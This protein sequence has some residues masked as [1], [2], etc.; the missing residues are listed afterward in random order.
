[1]DWHQSHDVIVVGAG[2]AGIEAALAA[3]RIGART[4]LLTLNLDTVGKMSCNPAIGGLAKGHLVRE[5]D[6]LGG[7]M[8]RAI[9]A[10]GIQFR[11]LNTRKGPAVWA[12]RAQADRAA[13]GAHMKRV[14]EQ[15]PGL[16]VLQAEVVGLWVQ[17]RELQG[18][19]SREG[20]RYPGR[21]V[22]LCPGTFLNGLAHVG[23][24]RFP[25][26]RA[27][28]PPSRE[29]AESLRDLGFPMG[30]LKTGTPPRLN[31][32]TIRWEDLE[33]QHGDPDPFP[34]SVD[35]PA[36]ERPQATCHITY[37]TARTHEIIRASLD[38]SPLYT[39][40]IEGVGPRYCPSI[41]D[42]VVRFADRDRHQVF[43]EPEGLDTSEV[44]PNGVS[45]S[46]PLDVQVAI[47]RSIPGLEEAEIL[48]PGYAIEY[49]FVDPRDLFPTLESKRLPGLFLAGQIN[50]TSGYE[51]AAAQGILAGINA[52]L[53]AGGSDPVTV[54]RH[55][56]YLGVLVD[57]LV[58][59]GIKEPYRMFTSRAEFRLLLRED[60][61][62][63][64]LTPLGLRVGSV[65]PERA[66]RFR[67]RT[68]RLAELRS[69]LK[70]TRVQPGPAVDR[71]LT[72]AGSSP[73]REPAALEDLLRRPGVSLEALQ[74]LA[75]GWPPFDRRDAVTAEVEVKYEGYVRRD[76]E[77]IEQVRRLEATPLPPDLDYTRIEGLAAEV[78]QILQEAR[79]LT[80]AQALR[81]PG[82]RPSAG[83]VLLVHLKRIGA[84]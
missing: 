30:R 47:V 74:P 65:L 28:E 63:L 33:V 2:H 23:L 58:T 4:L 37:T 20:V 83:P 13:Y 9:D 66:A 32:R 75:D 81:I 69:F 18:V 42:K 61:A 50:G 5:V 31:G 16:T 59:K 80:L 57:D 55:E 54:A 1:M 77:G 14:V 82:V 52:A 6:A 64:R 70:H 24:N 11:R 19:V 3:A 26:G 49:D 41:E 43:L 62:D 56:G 38:R 8:G 48:R 39:G 40:V 73:L 21:T 36:I 27:G 25:A 72:A 51:E 76:L 17:G 84:L 68:D 79:P 10:T 67:R 53:R 78:R 15:Q 22:V 35:T 34:F 45:T 7:E 44:Y 29:L 12:S 46:L 71:V 60:N